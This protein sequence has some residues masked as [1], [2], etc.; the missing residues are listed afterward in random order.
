VGC[1]DLRLAQQ[2]PGDL[3]GLPRGEGGRTR[4]SR[5]EWWPEEGSRGILFFDELNRAPVDVRQAV[6]Q[7]VTEWRL[8][9][10]T[11]PAGWVIVSAVNPDLS[12]YQVESLD[13]AMLRRFCQVRITPAAAEWIRWA[14][15]YKVH[16]GLI[17]FIRS[18]HD[19]LMRKEEIVIEA[20]PNPE[21]YRLIHELLGAGAIPEGV[22]Q[23]VFCGLVGTE[24]GT[25]LRH[26]ILRGRGAFA[27]GLEI[28]DGYAGV[29]DRVLAQRH[30]EMAKTAESL[31]SVLKEREFVPS[32]GQVANLAACL[33]DVA[34]EWKMAILSPLLENQGLL[35][36]LGA[37]AELAR[38][39]VHVRTE[40]NR[41]LKE[42]GKGRKP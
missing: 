10:H 4:W 8:H 34:A 42:K 1:I 19:L 32:D 25:A 6:F 39:I 31:A 38:Q 20:R 3:I 16:Q 41:A 36:R 35:M 13:I 7:L 15:R 2:E 17:D 23:E 37:D 9:T 12:G 40:V 5:P 18:N 28:L 27:G 24:A 26:F 14:E 33:K 29:R 22:E 11:L 21:G 30:D